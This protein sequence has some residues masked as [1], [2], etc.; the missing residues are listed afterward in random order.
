M[1]AADL[2]GKKKNLPKKQVISAN[3]ILSHPQR[4]AALSR[5]KDKEQCL[6]GF[7]LF[8]KNHLSPLSVLEVNQVTC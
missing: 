6:T 5:N 8:D 4:Q 2:M 1:A 7:L 3:V